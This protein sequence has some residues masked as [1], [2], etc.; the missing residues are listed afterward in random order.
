[1]FIWFPARLFPPAFIWNTAPLSIPHTLARLHGGSSTVRMTSG[2]GATVAGAH[3]KPSSVK[4]THGEI[5]V[6]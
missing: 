5:G 3:G 2:M 1:M 4:Q 6:F